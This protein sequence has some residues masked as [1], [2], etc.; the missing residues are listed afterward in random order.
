MGKYIEITVAVETNCGEK[1]R[2]LEKKKWGFELKMEGFYQ[3][4]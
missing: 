2:G 4:D 3:E 1:S